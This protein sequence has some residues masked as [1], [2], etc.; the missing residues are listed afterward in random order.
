[1][2]LSN[3]AMSGWSVTLTVLCGKSAILYKS[4]KLKDVSV[5]TLGNICNN[6][7]GIK[8]LTY[9]NGHYTTNSLHVSCKNSFVY[10]FKL[11][12]LTHTHAFPP[13]HTKSNKTAVS[14]IKAASFCRE[15]KLGVWQEGLQIRGASLQRFLSLSHIRLER[16]HSHT[17]QA[18]PHGNLQHDLCWSIPES[19]MLPDA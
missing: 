3:S 10:S 19:I 8:P 5:C 9:L 14:A 11:I 18:L 13:S 2:H 7:D 12:S 6:I 4:G 16:K 17:N 15:M 1:M